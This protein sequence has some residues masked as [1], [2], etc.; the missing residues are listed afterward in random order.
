MITFDERVLNTAYQLN[1]TEEE[2]CTFIEGHRDAVSHMSLS[3]IHI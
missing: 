2:I 1:E 3:L